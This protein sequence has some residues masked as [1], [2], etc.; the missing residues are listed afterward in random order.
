MVICHQ[1]FG[2]WGA[3]RQT[4]FSKGLRHS[5]CPSP[6]N[7]SKVNPLCSLALLLRYFIKWDSVNFRRSKLVDVTLNSFCHFWIFSKMYKQLHLDLVIIEMPM[8]IIFTNNKT[9]S[10]A[11]YS[12]HVLQIG[13]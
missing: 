12:G 3:S 13:F 11:E 1:D 5:R 7:D 4:L 6:I 8:P 2:F 9:F 10:R